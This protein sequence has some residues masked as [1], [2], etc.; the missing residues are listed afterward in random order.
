P[1]PL[2]PPAGCAFHP[3]CPIARDV[4][5]HEAP[6]WKTLGPGWRVRCHCA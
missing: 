4:C 5:R 1:S 3:R 2:D 6:G